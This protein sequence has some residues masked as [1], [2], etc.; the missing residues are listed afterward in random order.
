MTVVKPR[1]LRVAM[2]HLSDWKLDSRIQ[3][4][5]RALAE[6]GDEVHLV[7]IGE[8][9][10]EDCGAGR[11]VVHPVMSAKPQ[12]GYGAY[13]AGYGGFL[14]AATRKLAAL[15]RRQRLD[16]VE[17][18]NMPDLLT[19]AAI[20]PR[21][22]GTPVVLN[23][24]DTFPELFATKFDRAPRDPLVRLVELEE[25]VSAL[26]ADRVITVTE[27]AADRLHSRGVGVGRTV[28]VMNT[29]DE[30]AFGPARQPV[31]VPT[32]GP[33]KV[34]YH[35]GLAP[36][37]GVEVLVRS[38][39][40]LNGSRERVQLRVI[41]SGEDRDRLAG[42][43]HEIAPERIDVAAEPV[44]F[45]EI[46]NEL[47]AAH[48]GV[49]PTIQ[50]HFTELLLPVKLM[51]YVHAGLPVVA[52]RLPAIERYFGDEAARLFEPGSAPELAAAIEDILHDPAAAQQRAAR[53]T[54]RLAPLGWS[55]QRRRYL[56]M[57]DELTA[58]RE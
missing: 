53:A 3:R 47:A 36:R 4:L 39:G 28:V 33:V 32:D 42:I 2:V 14:L 58:A 24:H 18:H 11:I 44:P 5:A 8:P 31:C 12:G 15:G 41:G 37:F 16:M 46:P 25:R 30:S 13:L 55:E 56:A 48:V 7:C 17:A 52:S 10:V 1:A 35:G 43:A 19:A 34:L 38:I 57:V 23:V 50:D 6:R 26:L 54:D 9:T 21:L 51:E 27:E 20:V 22:K 29:P 49:V 45:A 40:H